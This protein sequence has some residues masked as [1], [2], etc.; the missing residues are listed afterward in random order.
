MCRLRNIAIHDYQESM[1]TG[2]TH[3]R[4]DGQT[5]AGQMIPMCCYVSQA[6]HTHK[7][8]RIRNISFEI[9]IFC[10]TI[11]LLIRHVGHR[12]MIIEVI[13]VVC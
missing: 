5:D 6:T 1:T 8:K 4:T 13:V 7:K 3:R 12:T 10:L 11:F 2:Q 9:L